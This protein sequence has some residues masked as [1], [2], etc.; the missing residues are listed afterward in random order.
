MRYP[1]TR[2]GNPTELQYYSQGLSEKE[3]AKE[4]KRSEKTVKNWLQGKY[5]I[6]FWVP[7][8][9]RLRHLE[10]EI[11]FKQMGIEGYRQRFGIVKADVLEFKPIAHIL[12]NIETDSLPIPEPAR[13]AI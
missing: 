7:E 12:D 1:N 4:L 3:L 11:K 9:M 6:P 2:Y 10:A 5:K 8:L 13:Y